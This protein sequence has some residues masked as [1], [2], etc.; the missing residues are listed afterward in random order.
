MAG[1]VTK[2]KFIDLGDEPMDMPMT[3][4]GLPNKYY[5]S[6]RLKK[7]GIKKGVG[8]TGT[9]LVRFKVRSVELRDGQ[10]PETCLEITG[11]REQD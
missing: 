2:G 10:R 8:K 3:S 9:A 5:P 6:I 4:K 11:I 7:A 1:K